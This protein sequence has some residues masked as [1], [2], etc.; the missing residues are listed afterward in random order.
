MF[1]HKEMGDKSSRVQPEG[2]GAEHPPQEH[3]PIRFN[4]IWTS[5]VDRSVLR[6]AR[7]REA[8]LRGCK[9]AAARFISAG[10]RGSLSVLSRARA[11]F[12]IALLLRSLSDRFS[13]AEDLS[14]AGGM[15]VFGGLHS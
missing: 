2:P 13:A 15:G 3:P 1:V 12:D 6:G 7:H 8:I 4:G 11:A 5:Y 14:L 9:T 10:V